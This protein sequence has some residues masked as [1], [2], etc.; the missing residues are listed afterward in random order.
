MSRGNC[1]KKI[2]INAGMMVQICNFNYS[3]GRDKFKARMGKLKKTLS[4]KTK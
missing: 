1:S 2:A 4:L 3:G